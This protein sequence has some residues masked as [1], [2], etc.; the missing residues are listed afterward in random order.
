MTGSSDQ[1]YQEDEVAGAIQKGL[2]PLSVHLVADPSKCYACSSIGTRP[3][4]PTN[5]HKEMV[6]QVDSSVSTD[7]QLSAP[8][9]ITGLSGRKYRRRY[10]LLNSFF[11]T[12][13][14]RSV[15]TPPSPTRVCVDEGTEMTLSTETVQTVAR[16]FR[17]RLGVGPKRVCLHSKKTLIGS[18]L[19]SS[20]DSSK[21]LHQ[22]LPYPNGWNPSSL[23]EC[24]TM[25]AEPRRDQA[26][27]L[28][29]GLARLSRPNPFQQ[30]RQEVRT[31]SLV[32]RRLLRAWGWGLIAV[33]NDKSL[34][35]YLRI[36]NH[37][38]R[39]VPNTD[40]FE[41]LGDPPLWFLEILACKE[42][43]GLSR[44]VNLFGRFRESVEEEHSPMFFFC[45]PRLVP[46][47]VNSQPRF[48]EGHTQLS[49]T[50]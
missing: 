19:R 3:H 35:D 15:P 43:I 24:S 7:G 49:E 11:P 39:K 47:M 22:S 40:L 23:V 46:H 48:V 10:W 33:R 12:G 2:N 4:L 32:R 45:S 1:T 36:G 29:P 44:G 17:K 8:L 6:M 42:M 38:T 27:K 30:V 41:I 37:R 5:L 9:P 26:W 31:S 50:N 18:L 14:L 16:E 21:R 25:R 28:L 34:L 20:P 13:F